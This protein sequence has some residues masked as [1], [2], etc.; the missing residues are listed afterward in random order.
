MKDFSEFVI[1]FNCTIQEL[2]LI[3][4]PRGQDE[5]NQFQLHHTGIKTVYSSSNL[6]QKILFQLHHTGIKTGE[7]A[8]M[9][10][11]KLEISIAPYRN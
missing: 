7:V 1:Y 3:L 5:I 9:N 6:L 2:K 11:R 8:E 10:I 4:P